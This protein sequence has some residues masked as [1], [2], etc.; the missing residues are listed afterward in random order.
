M[1]LSDLIANQIKILLEEADGIAEIKRNELAEKMGCVPSQIN[2]VIESRF[3]TEQGYIVESRRGGGGYIR[4]TKVKMDR[5]TMLMHVV[6]NIGT[7]IDASSSYAF[8]R[9]LLDSRLISLD[10]AHVM[11]AA[12]SDKAYVN[13]PI[14]LRDILRASLLKNMLITAI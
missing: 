1:R 6:N 11:G 10:V 14:N 9:N 8:I 5:N 2:Y 7:E 13:V 3:T 4:I 12:V